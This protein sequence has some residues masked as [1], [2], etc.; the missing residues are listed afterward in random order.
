MRYSLLLFYAL[1]MAVPGLRAQQASAY[2]TLDLDAF[3]GS[4]LL[5]NTDISH[6]IASHPMGLIL[7]LNNR[8]FG[9]EPWQQ[10]YG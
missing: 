8:T 9:E 2:R 3:Y 10:D 6:L 1:A 5:H 7:A 4:V